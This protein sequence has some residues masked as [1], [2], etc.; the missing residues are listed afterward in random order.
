M[1]SVWS[2]YVLSKRQTYKIFDF[3]VV[4]NMSSGHKI[5]VTFP[6]VSCLI[7]K[8]IVT[9]IQFS[10]YCPTSCPCEA[11]SNTTFLPAPLFNLDKAPT[12]GSFRPLSP[13]LA[14]PGPRPPLGKKPP[15]FRHFIQILCPFISINGPADAALIGA[16]LNNRLNT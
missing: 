1:N 3:K 7:V 6:L 16:V 9:S 14:R 5:C 15:Q 2:S 13:E 12:V 4:V 10:I 8:A 11:K